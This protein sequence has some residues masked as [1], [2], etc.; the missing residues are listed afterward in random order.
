MWCQVCQQ[1]NKDSS[2]RPLLPLRRP[3]RLFFSSATIFV[4]SILTLF[5][6]LLVLPYSLLGCISTFPY[7]C[8]LPPI[9]SNLFH[10]IKLN[11]VFFLL[12]SF[13]FIFSQSMCSLS[14]TLS[15][16]LYFSLVASIGAEL[17]V[18]RISHSSLLHILF[19]LFFFPRVFTI[20]RHKETIVF[21]RAIY[22]FCRM[23][24]TTSH[25]VS[26]CLSFCTPPSVPGIVSSLH[27]CCLT[28]NEW[29]RGVQNR[30]ESKLW[31]K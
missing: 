19:F 3:A 27:C 15:T 25:H 14:I 23:T 6:F 5:L 31:K 4:W 11:L 2:E 16:S 13:F 1:G 17:S 24:E 20:G 28:V 12:F 21:L 9:F 29:P 18:I 26:L 8:F 30:F 22:P 7:L 10:R